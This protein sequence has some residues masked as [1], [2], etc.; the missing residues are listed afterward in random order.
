[1]QIEEPEFPPVALMSVESVEPTIGAFYDTISAAFAS[2]NPA[3]NG[4]SNAIVIGSAK[5]INSVQDALDAIAAIKQEGEGTPQSPSEPATDNGQLAHYYL[6]K[7][8][9]MGKRLLETA[10]TWHFDG[11]PIS[12]PGV[13][14]FSTSAAS[15]DPSLAFNQTLAALLQGLE[16]C[17]VNGSPFN[18]GNMDSLAQEGM[19]LIQAG[20]RPAFQW[21]R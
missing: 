19:A 9:F 20:V 3:I 17:W 4:S 1:M 12:M 8:V 13:L 14:Q 21:P 5:R 15:P 7:E 18:R 2:I 11:S 16:A 6:F 10:G